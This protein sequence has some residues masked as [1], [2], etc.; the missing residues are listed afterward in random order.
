M[1]TSLSLPFR[2]VVLLFLLLVILLFSAVKSRD[3]S[4]LLLIFFHH[5]RDARA[6]VVNPGSRRYLAD[7]EELGR[8]RCPM[9]IHPANRSCSRSAR[10]TPSCASRS[11]RSAK[12][13]RAPIGASWRT[14]RPT[15]PSLSRR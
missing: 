13:I 9:V 3:F 5:A 6:R 4:G 2:P 1:P 8:A 10:T 12:D 11:A 15:R 14:S 7:G